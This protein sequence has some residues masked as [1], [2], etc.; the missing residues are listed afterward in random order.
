MRKLYLSSIMID[1]VM[2]SAE[3]DSGPDVNV[4]DRQFKALKIKINDERESPKEAQPAWGT[5]KMLSLRR[6][7]SSYQHCKM[8]YK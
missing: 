1:D 4:N 5:E 6:A 7:K 2:A 8:H 3:P